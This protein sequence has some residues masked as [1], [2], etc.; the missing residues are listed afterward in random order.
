VGDSRTGE[1]RKPVIQPMRGLTLTHIPYRRT[2][3]DG[4]R[5]VNGEDSNRREWMGRRNVWGDTRKPSLRADVM[6]SWG[7]RRRAGKAE[8]EVEVE[9]FPTQLTSECNGM[10]RG[11]EIE[12]VS[13]RM[14]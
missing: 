2:A 14:Y 13:L 4:N 7:E 1:D 6:K 9:I 11:R 3:S 12:R 10:V 5:R 8:G